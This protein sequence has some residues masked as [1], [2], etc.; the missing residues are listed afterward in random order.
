M[1]IRLCGRIRCIRFGREQL[2]SEAQGN[3]PIAEQSEQK[4][5]DSDHEAE[6]ARLREQVRQLTKERD[7]LGQSLAALSSDYK[8]SLRSLFE[9]LK[10][11]YGE[12]APWP[13][14]EEECM[15]FRQVVV[16]LEKELE[17][18]KHAASS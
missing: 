11:R 14:N 9:Y 12:E 6:C 10:K 8:E 5:G 4:R 16:E 1:E 15:D 13:E 3:G 7:S 2:M 17:D 18:M